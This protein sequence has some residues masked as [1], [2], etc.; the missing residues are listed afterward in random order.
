MHKCKCK[1]ITSIGLGTRHHFKSID[2]APVSKKPQ[3]IPNPNV[4]R[5]DRNTNASRGSDVCI[6]VG[7]LH[8][9]QT[10]MQIRFLVCVLRLL[11]LLDN[12]Y[13]IFNRD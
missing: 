10:V 2:L 5:H 13:F 1:Y 4:I 8:A 7:K 3:T 6:L 11:V 12:D 9:I